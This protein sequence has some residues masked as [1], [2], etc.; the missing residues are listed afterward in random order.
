[1]A[2]KKSIWQ[3]I[4]LYAVH[5]RVDKLNQRLDELL[6]CA[7]VSHLNPHDLNVQVQSLLE[8]GADINL[9]GNWLDKKNSLLLFA[10]TTRNQELCQYLLT[11]HADVN[12]PNANGVTPLCLAVSKYDTLI[13]KLLKLGAKIDTCDKQ[14]ITPLMKAAK[15]EKHRLV[16]Y[17]LTKGAKIT[18]TDKHRQSVLFY[19]G[20][21]AQITKTLLE[22]GANPSQESLAGKTPL[23]L[24]QDVQ[25]A[26]ML[27]NYGAD[28]NKQDLEKRTP[29]MTMANSPKLVKILLAHGANPTMR[30]SVQDTALHFAQNPQS[31]HLLIEAGADINAQG[32]GQET[33][34]L[35]LAKNPY[36]TPRTIQALLRYNPLPLQQPYDITGKNSTRPN[37]K[38]LN[39]STDLLSV[40]SY[41]RDPKIKNLLLNYQE[42]WDRKTKHT[43]ST[44]CRT[45][46][47]LEMT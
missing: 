9:Q 30:D 12:L 7:S 11:K 37:P 40:W 45:K 19:T 17:L 46:F 15:Y 18:L 10:I 28:V 44:S 2:L 6:S 39:S 13:P 36:I 32:F 42:K 29:L 16:T 1:M 8:Q 38:D 5:H 47:Y 20:S 21:N 31:I 35:R 41:I 3:R 33:P 24:A 14:G 34:L 23:F 26:E 22:K 25:V 43:R 27:L 4:K